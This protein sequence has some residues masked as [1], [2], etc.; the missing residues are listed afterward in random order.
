MSMPMQ[1]SDGLLPQDF[2]WAGRTFPDYMVMLP[3]T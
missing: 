1:I 2:G 3:V